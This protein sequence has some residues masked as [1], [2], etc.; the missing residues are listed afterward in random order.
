[1]L[2]KAWSIEL[3][4]ILVCCLNSFSGWLNC[5]G[6][7]LGSYVIYFKPSRTCCSSYQKYI[8]VLSGMGYLILNNNTKD[9][10]VW[11]SR[12]IQ[13]TNRKSFPN[14]HDLEYIFRQK[15][16]IPPESL[17]IHT[18]FILWCSSSIYKG[19]IGKAEEIV[20]RYCKNTLCLSHLGKRPCRYSDAEQRQAYKQKALSWK[21]LT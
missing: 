12:A 6:L 3:P 8:L 15:L 20:Q 9:K 7:F 18:V 17:H 4:S 10:I 14:P 11:T 13:E 21:N 1:M 2:V 16:S 5:T 19:C